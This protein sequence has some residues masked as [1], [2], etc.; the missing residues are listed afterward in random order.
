MIVDGSIVRDSHSLVIACRSSLVNEGWDEGSS[1]VVE[2]G[3]RW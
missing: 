2:D 3:G 1:R